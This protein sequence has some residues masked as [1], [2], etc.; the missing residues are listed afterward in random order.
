[1]IFCIVGKSCGGKDTILKKLSTNPLLET[2]VTMTSR[3]IRSNEKNGIDYNFVTSEEFDTYDFIE[4][5]EFNGWK[6]GTPIN[7]IDINKNQVIVVNPQGLNALIDKYGWDNIVSF[8]IHRK[9]RDRLLSY[10][11][12]DENADVEEMIRRYYA[13]NKDFSKLGTMK[14]KNLY[15]IHNEGDIS[16][17]LFTIETIIGGHLV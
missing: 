6:Y 16:E 17:V 7:A 15:H 1:M 13:D 9:D 4:R 5:C 2:V 12:R 14:H 3:P 8:V 11:K 10:L